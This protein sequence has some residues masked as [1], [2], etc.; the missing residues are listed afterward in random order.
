MLTLTYEKADDWQPLQIR[1]FMK[2]LQRDLGENLL[3]Y[4]WVLEMQKRGAPHYHVLLYV[5]RGTRIARP[6]DGLWKY[7]SS[8]IE[9]AQSLF[10]ICKYTGKMYQKEELPYGARMFAVKI[11]EAVASAIDILAFRMSG[12]PA[13]L[14]EHLEAVVM[15]KGERL[16]WSRCPGG[17]WIIRNTGELLQSPW[18]VRAIVEV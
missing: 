9:T 4:A 1:N 17:G 2:A 7:G 6:D 10:Y 14:R 18:R 12:S 8:R 15:A 11:N 13:W 16:R 5:Q 3:G